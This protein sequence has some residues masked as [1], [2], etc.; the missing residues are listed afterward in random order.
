MATVDMI[1][2]LMAHT[3]LFAGLTAEERL[4][5]ARAAE[6]RRVERGSII[7]SQG[8]KASG[9]FLVLHGTVRIFQ[10]SPEGREVML[11]IVE[12]GQ[13]IAEAA[14]FQQAAVY[15]AS[16]QALKASR[17]LYIPA[18]E[19][20][21]MV[22]ER[23]QLALRM[24]GALS[25]RLREF[26]RMLHEQ[27]HGTAQSRL[28]GWLLDQARRQEST[29]VTLGIS[30]EVLAGM[31]GLTRETLSR[32]LSRLRDMGCLEVDRRTLRIVDM[33]CLKRLEEGRHSEL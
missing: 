26:T 20:I 18:Q 2:S 27:Q 33:E 32:T 1:A 7:F 25:A 5:L 15:P 19:I 17:L 9:M 30:R 11:H 24:L 14:V 16:A 12:P 29:S 22:T 13:T 8:A 23:P 6:D 3:P 10:V 21:R 31:L 28:A 4:S